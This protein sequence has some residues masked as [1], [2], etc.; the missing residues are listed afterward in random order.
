MHVHIAIACIYA[1]YK[2]LYERLNVWPRIA[3]MEAA[4]KTGN[5]FYKQD[6][7][8]RVAELGIKNVFKEG[9]W[10]E[11]FDKKHGTLSWNLE[12]TGCG[13][14]RTRLHSL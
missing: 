12:P 7:Q 10:V 8:K 2:H 5:L 1:N 11:P 13:I 9:P 3:L 14:W 4:K 6:I